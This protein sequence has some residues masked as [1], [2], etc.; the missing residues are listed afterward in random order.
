[1][2]KLCTFQHLSDADLY[3]IAH[4]MNTSHSAGGCCTRTCTILKLMA[5]TE[6]IISLKASPCIQDA[7]TML[8]LTQQLWEHISEAC[9]CYTCVLHTRDE[10]MRTCLCVPSTLGNLVESD[11]V[12]SAFQQIMEP[13][14]SE[15]VAASCDPHTLIGSFLTAKFLHV[16]P[17]KSLPF[18]D[19]LRWLVVLGGC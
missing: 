7:I 15:W 11:T 1:M 3:V 8:M 19:S 16:H 10:D 9:V 6:D 13:T 18:I 2:L 17:L 14:V 12:R 5:P 4:V